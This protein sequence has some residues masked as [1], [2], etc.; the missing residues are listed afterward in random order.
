MGEERT[1]LRA[2]VWNCAGAFARKAAALDALR[3]D[4]AIVA[5]CRRDDVPTATG[6]AVWIGAEGGKGLAVL[7]AGGWMVCP[8]PLVVTERW[9]LPVLLRRGDVELRMLAV[10]VKPDGRYVAPTLRALEHCRSFLAEGPC[11]VAGD[12]NQNIRFD[13]PPRRAGVIRPGFVDVVACFRAIGL[14]SA[15]HTWRVEPFGQET[16]STLFMHRRQS[17]GYHIDYVFLVEALLAG[18]RNVAIGTFEDWIATGL[19]DHAPVIVDIDIA[20]LS[21]P[22]RPRAGHPAFS[23]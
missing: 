20:G 12:F 18:V 2:V 15:W 13:R 17:R 5:E 22:G 3:P 19:S 14:A 10:W 4:I 1:D 16:A 21:E 9:F 7:A 23:P 11:I 8:V 6:G